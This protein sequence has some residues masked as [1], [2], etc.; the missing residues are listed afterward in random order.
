[1]GNLEGILGAGLTTTLTYIAGAT[2][3]LVYAAAAYVGAAIGY[4]VRK[5][6]S[7]HK[8]AQSH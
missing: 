5:P 2:N 1:M 3:P 7:S 6:G 4:N 8:P